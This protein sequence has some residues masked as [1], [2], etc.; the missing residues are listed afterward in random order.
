MK[1]LI[2]SILF[3]FLL[4]I[5]FSTCI[6]WQGKVTGVADGDTITV[7]HNDKQE[8]IRLYGIDTPEALPRDQR[9]HRKTSFI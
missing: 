2:Q 3:I 1:C 6:A 9:A 5:P 8:K 7:M 4:L